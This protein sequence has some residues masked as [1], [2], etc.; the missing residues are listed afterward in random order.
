MSVTTPWDVVPDSTS[1]F[2]LILPLD[3]V[4]F[5]RNFISDCWKGL[6]F[7]G[8]S[9]DSVQA[10]NTSKDTEGS[11]VWAERNP[12]TLIPGYFVRI[13]RNTITGVSPKSRH[14]GIGCY[15]GHPD[16]EATYK[17]VMA[18][19]FEAVENTISG[20]PQAKPIDATEAPPYSGIAVVAAAGGAPTDGR[21]TPGS[22]TNTILYGNHLAN[23]A[24]G[25]TIDYSLD[26]TVM[27]NNTYTATVLAFLRD[28]G[29]GLHAVVLSNERT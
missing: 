7:F 22:G 20:E 5:Y 29:G 19:E 26:G 8:N 10:D 6:W 15:T 2:A 3:Q 12:G 18:Y 21:S 28:E 13:A 1:T 25:V 11:F 14:G 17:T 16:R 9:F 23:L 24:A 27:M 4:T